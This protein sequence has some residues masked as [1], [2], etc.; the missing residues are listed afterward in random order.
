MDTRD[1]SERREAFYAK[2]DESASPPPLSPTHADATGEAVDRELLS[3]RLECD[4][5]RQLVKDLSAER[6][7]VAALASV[8]GDGA[9][10]TAATAATAT[11]DAATE[12]ARNA[13]QRR[14]SRTVPPASNATRDDVNSLRKRDSVALRYLLR[15]YFFISY[16]LPDFFVLFYAFFLVILAFN[17]I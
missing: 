14:G 11:A 16:F 9:A 17:I 12:A 3:L 15:F 7:R 2:V 5:L 4:T 13:L 10:A 6:D 1:I 8:N